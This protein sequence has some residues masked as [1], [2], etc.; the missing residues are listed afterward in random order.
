MST[1]LRSQ[2]ARSELM[3]TLLPCHDQKNPV[4]HQKKTRKL[5][6]GNSTDVCMCKTRRVQCVSVLSAG[7]GLLCG[8]EGRSS[9]RRPQLPW[10]PPYTLHTT[11]VGAGVSVVELWGRRT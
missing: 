7:F 8:A 3:L 11:Y 4:E 2:G 9:T 1:R 10:G 5:K 6:V